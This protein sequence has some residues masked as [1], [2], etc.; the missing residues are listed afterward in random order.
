[1]FLDF[2]GTVWDEFEL[3]NVSKY[4]AEINFIILKYVQKLQWIVIYME[5]T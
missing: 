4:N 5:H 1:M 3:K 2:L